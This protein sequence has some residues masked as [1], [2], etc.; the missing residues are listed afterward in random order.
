MTSG[1]AL[2]VS[3]FLTLLLVGCLND[4]SPDI[5]PR[6]SPEAEGVAS[7]GI[8]KFVEAVERSQSEFHSFMFLRHGKVIAEGYWEPY[9]KD[10]KNTLYSATK[11][12][13]STAVG[14]AVSEGKLSV[15]EPVISFFSDEL[16]DTLSAYHTRLTVKDLLTMSAGQNPIHGTIAGEPNW[17]KVFWNSPVLHEPGTMFQ[18]NSLCSHMLS[19]IIQKVT[20]EKLIDYLTPRLFEPLGI[21]GMDWEED[22]QG[23]NTGGWG[24][25]IKT[26]DMAKFG[27]L[28]L[29]NGI[30][31]SSKILP[32]EWIEEATS[33]KIEQ[34][35]DLP[36]S[37]KDSSDWLQGYC[38]QFWRCRHNAFRADGANG[39]FIVV[40][41]DQD[42]VIAI[43]SETIGGQYGGMQDELNLVWKYLL[44]AIHETDLP[45]DKK[46]AT[47]LKQKLS[48]LALP[49]PEKK[50]TPDFVNNITGKSFTMEPNKA[51]FERMSFSITGEICH[52]TIQAGTD[53]YQLAFGSSSWAPGETTKSG[54]SM[55]T[56]VRAGSGKLLPIKVAGC[57]NW[58][59]ENKL[60]LVLRYTETPHSATMICSFDQNKITVEL[61]NSRNPQMI[62][63]LLKGE[64]NE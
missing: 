52:V 41:P 60:R 23:I 53:T 36:Q 1:K 57:Y 43:T 11:S 62:F 14:F 56:G 3:L 44:P 21:T 35:P 64:L 5:L 27:Q 12:F 26:E 13:S 59:D 29:Q 4:R 16:P 63:S 30:W 58:T 40:M 15:D 51:H 55:F 39:Q 8:L 32:E 19:A 6:S 61:K 31:K 18:Y 24:L 17:V 34:A 42:A 47:A 28:Y 49:L 54:N 2:F 22:P 25:R 33:I 9:T 37:K 38:Y 7:E 10:L 50:D 20:G 48:S 45:A 46:M